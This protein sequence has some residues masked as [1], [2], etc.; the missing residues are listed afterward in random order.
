MVSIYSQLSAERKQGQLNGDIPNW[1]TTG[2]YQMF[3]NKYAMPGQTI[4]ERYQ[5]IA[6]AAGSLAYEMYGD[7]FY[8][9]ETW[10]EAFFNIIWRGWLSPSTPVLLNMGTDRGMPVS[11]AGSYVDDSILGFYESR[12]EAAVLTK[13][14]FGTS[15]YMGDIRSRGSSISFG[16]KALGS[17][18]VFDGF[19]KDMEDV[20]QG[21]ARRGSW[22]GYLDV[23]HGDFDEVSDKLLSHPDG[24]NVGWIITDEFISRLDKGDRDAIRRYQKVLRIRAITGKGYMF[25]ID[26]VNRQN[27][28]MYEKNSLSVKASNLCAEIS[29]HS[30]A[31]HTFT[32]V[33]SSMNLA[34]W[35]EWKDTGAVKLATVFLDCVAEEFIRKGENVRG[36]EKAIRFTKKSRALG[37]GVLGLH[38]LFQ[39]KMLPF[40]SFGAHNLNTQIFK[41]ISARAHEASM[42]MAHVA[43]E[44]E[45]CN[46]FGVRNTHL[47]AIAPTM[48]TA[49][50]CG[51]VSQGIEPLA[52]NTFNQNSAAGEIERINPTLLKIMKERE[53][54]NDE[55]IKRMVNDHGS[56]QNVNWLSE[57]E[58]QVFKTAYEINQEAIIRMASV[59]QQFVDQ[60]QSLNLFFDADEDPRYISEIHKMAMKDPNIKSLYYMRSKAGIQA[61]KG[62]CVAC[63][64]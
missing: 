31:E 41:S 8:T 2:G 34:L 5:E 58:K 28:P 59:R 56:V 61:S 23:D 20:S 12:L 22:A 10:S 38:T 27:P 42:D 63:E 15:S 45:W 49:L 54:Y 50:I 35:D 16:G 40:E 39:K 21:S 36:L 51:G 24:L 32:C 43:G 53:V 55:T 4:K 57:D 3:K 14:G 9:Q 62:E 33:L 17:M 46:G 48:S 64:G 1:Y 52:A 26:K 60:G 25:F 18:P 11:C 37:L 7:N 47:M 44:P 19:V 13:N 29:L 6:N 30:D